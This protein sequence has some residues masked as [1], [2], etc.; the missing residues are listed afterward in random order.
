MTT[1][2]QPELDFDNDKVD[3]PSCKKY[4]N[5]LFNEAGKNKAKK[6]KGKSVNNNKRSI[7]NTDS[8]V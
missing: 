4:V 5:L 7:I 1:I 3:R 8:Q 6:K 2:L